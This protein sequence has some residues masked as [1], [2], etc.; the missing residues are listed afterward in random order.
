[1]REILQNVS[2][3]VGADGFGNTFRIYT[4]LFIF[5][6]V[7]GNEPRSSHVFTRARQALYHLSHASGPGIILESFLV[8]GKTV[9]VGIGV[10]LKW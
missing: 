3:H 9:P 5:R 6:V 7:L 4:Y 10:W 2:L 1:M 8:I